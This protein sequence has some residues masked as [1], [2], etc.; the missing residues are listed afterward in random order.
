[1]LQKGDTPLIVAANTGDEA[2][3]QH[4][5]DHNANIG[6]INFVCHSFALLPQ[7]IIMP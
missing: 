5:I 1:M 4:L 6:A 3:A 2:I 7:L